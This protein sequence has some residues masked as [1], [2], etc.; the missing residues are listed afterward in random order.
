MALTTTYLISSKNLEPLLNAVRTAR[1]P[2]KFTQKFLEDLGFKNTN[3]RLFIPLLKSLKFLDENG[4]PLKRYFDFLDD[5]RWK[6]VLAEGARDA[7]EDLFR[8][9]KNA[10]NLSQPDIIGKLK[11]LTEGKKSE[12]VIANM[13]R[14]F[15]EIVRLADFSES[16]KVD[17]PG[18]SAKDKGSDEIPQESKHKD[19]NAKDAVHKRHGRLVDGITYRIELVLPSVRD[20]AVYDA[21]FRSLKEHLL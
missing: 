7:Y 9:N 21:I 19:E 3:D 8:L 15:S 17:V 12:S 14:T 10:Q 6:Q 13:A 1:A 2:E 5:G 11:S 18:N 4:V 16:T 20:Q